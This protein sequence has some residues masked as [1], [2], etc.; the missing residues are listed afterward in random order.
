MYILSSLIAFGS[1]VYAAGPNTFKI[2]QPPGYGINP[3][4]GGSAEGIVG[5]I[6]KNVVALFFVVGGI[7]ALIFFLWGAVEWIFS[8]GD[9]EKVAAARKRITN[10]LIGLALLSLAFVIVSVF[11][12]IVGFNPLGTLQIPG[13]GENLPISKN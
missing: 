8:G 2:V 4:A 10:S 5:I 6:L 3:S 11:G 9:K 7:G 13:L 1:K 12:R